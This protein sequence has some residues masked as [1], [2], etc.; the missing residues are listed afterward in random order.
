MKLSRPLCG[1][2]P[3]GRRPIRCGRLSLVLIATLSILWTGNS[4]ATTG[5]PEGFPPPKARVEPAIGDR[6]V[7]RFYLAKVERPARL[8]G[9]VF[10]IDYTEYVV[11]NFLVGTAQFYAYGP[12]GRPEEWTASMYP[13][14]YRARRLI[15]DLRAAGDPQLVVGYL[16]MA[17][18]TGLDTPLHPNRETIDSKLTIGRG[19]YNVTLVQSSDDAPVP[20]RIPRATQTGRR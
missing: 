10:E 11:N 20:T 16:T 19:T 1:C 13:F 8:I 3:V 17:P 12:S 5:D 15:C 4:P 18:P 9:A 2:W 14:E 7:G 6:Y